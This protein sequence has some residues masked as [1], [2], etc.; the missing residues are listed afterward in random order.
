MHTLP[1]FPWT[2][3][4]AIPSEEPINSEVQFGDGYK[5]VTRIGTKRIWQLRFFEDQKDQKRLSDIRQALAVN[6]L[7]LWTEPAPHQSGQPHIAKC[8]K[9]SY[10]EENGRLREVSCVFVLKYDGSLFGSA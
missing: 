9:H 10:Q 1:T 4:E 2:A 3:D 5:Q 7:F 6:D 8:S